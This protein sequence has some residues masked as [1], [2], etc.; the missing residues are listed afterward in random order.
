MQSS[1]IFYLQNI[2]IPLFYDLYDLRTL[3]VMVESKTTLSL[4]DFLLRSLSLSSHE[5]TVSLRKDAMEA[6]NLYREL[7]ARKRE[8]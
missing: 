6:E 2:S 1:C 5:E 8:R 7:F 4:K 3:M